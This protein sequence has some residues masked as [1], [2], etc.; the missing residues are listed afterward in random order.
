MVRGKSCRE[1]V[2]WGSGKDYLVVLNVGGRYAMADD[3]VSRVEVGTRSNCFA[4][5]LESRL[6]ARQWG[7]SIR[8]SRVG[9][10]EALVPRSGMPGFLPAGCFCLAYATGGVSGGERYDGNC[11]Y[12]LYRFSNWVAWGMK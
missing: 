9:G 6:W 8:E 12:R 5:V 1:D 2:P 3:V 11:V 4:G 10:V 7:L